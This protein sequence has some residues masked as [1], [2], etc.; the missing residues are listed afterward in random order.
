MAVGDGEGDEAAEVDASAGEETAG[1]ETAVVGVDE[2]EEAAAEARASGDDGVASGLPLQPA[3]REQPA[4]TA[5]APNDRRHGDAELDVPF[6][7]K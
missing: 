2:G 6:C 4:T 5:R 3:A 7:R 1:E